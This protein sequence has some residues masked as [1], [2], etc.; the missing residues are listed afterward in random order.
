MGRRP[1]LP[2]GRWGPVILGVLALGLL[3]WGAVTGRGEMVVVGAIGAAALLV[4]FPLAERVMG[5][6]EDGD[7]GT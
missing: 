3:I 6:G 1:V 5:K 7:D 2:V 4:G